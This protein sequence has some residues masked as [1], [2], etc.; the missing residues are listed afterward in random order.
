MQAQNYAKK[1]AD[2]VDRKK[3]FEEALGKFRSSD[4]EGVGPKSARARPEHAAPA[5]LSGCMC[6]CLYVR[7]GCGLE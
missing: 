4:I 2:E 1:K 5:C 3:L 7:T 6:A